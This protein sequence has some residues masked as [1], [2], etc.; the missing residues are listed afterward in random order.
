M[1]VPDFLNCPKKGKATVKKQESYLTIF[2]K[3]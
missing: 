3:I 1:S 2:F